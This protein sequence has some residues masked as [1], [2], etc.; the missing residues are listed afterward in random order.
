MRHGHKSSK[1]TEWIRDDQGLQLFVDDLPF[2]R[3]PEVSTVKL[4]GTH[5]ALGLDLIQFSHANLPTSDVPIPRVA[6]SP[7]EAGR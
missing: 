7:S 1:S 5:R 2:P 6:P 3:K 4:A